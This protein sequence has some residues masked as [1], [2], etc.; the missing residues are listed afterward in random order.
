MNKH[1]CNECD[2]EVDRLVFC[3]AT[4]RVRYHRRKGPKVPASAAPQDLIG[5]LRAKTEA[6][7][8]KPR[9]VPPIP[10]ISVQRSKSL[11]PDF[12]EEETLKI[13]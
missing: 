4:C 7:I 6:I 8:A 11:D 1:I 2:A 5:D 3:S 12:F 13:D 10:K 9:P